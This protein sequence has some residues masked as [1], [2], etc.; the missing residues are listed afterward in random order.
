MKKG[1]LTFVIILS[2]T[3]AYAQPNN[4]DAMTIR[5]V[6]KVKQL[7]DY[8][9]Y[10]ADKNMPIEDRLEYRQ[11]A[12]N[13]FIGQGESYIVNGSP[14]GVYIL[15]TSKYHK[16][17]VVRLMK[18]Y[19]TGLVNLRYN[20]VNIVSV[21]VVNDIKVSELKKV[22]EK[23]YE[24]TCTISAF[25]GFHDGKPIYKKIP[26]KRVTCR[27]FEEEAIRISSSGQTDKEV[28]YTVGL[29]DVEAIEVY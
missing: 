4:E 18:D 28:K 19:F 10:M 13:L 27:I 14:R 3:L 26:N 8:I 20:K 5:V 9:N 16:K 15:I 2:A 6:Q 24:C 22:G 29:G 11:A 7:T 1:I 21:E 25:C 12:L 23:E 17:P